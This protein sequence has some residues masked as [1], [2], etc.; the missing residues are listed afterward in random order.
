M[1]QV[2]HP[3]LQAILQRRRAADRASPYEI[4]L[5]ALEFGLTQGQIRGLLLK[6]GDDRASLAAAA[7]NLRAH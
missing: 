4:K 7:R 3:D 1:G 2:L 6:Y 5:L